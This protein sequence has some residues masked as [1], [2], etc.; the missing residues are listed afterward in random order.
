MISGVFPPMRLASLLAFTALTAAAPALAQTGPA[1]AAAPPQAAEDTAPGEIIVTATKRAENLQRVPIAVSVVSSADLAR[2]GGI[3]LENVQYLVPTLN[4]RKSGVPI[5]QSIF[6]RGVG[7]STF[8]IA[9][10]PSVS[11]VLDGVVLSRAGEAFTDLVDIERIEVLRGPQ[12]TLF[13]KNSSAGVVNIVSKKPTNKTQG[14][15]EGSYLTD[16]EFRARGSFNFALSPNL[17]TRLTGFYSDYDGNIRND[18]VRD[19]VNGYKHW[20]VRGTIVAD[21]SPDVHATLIGDYRKSRD[22]CCAEVIG[23]A[24]GGASAFLLGALPTPRGDRTRR[25]ANNT[26]NRNEEDS[27]GIS[28]QLDAEAHGITFTSITAY[29]DYSDREIRDGDFL[30]AAY[31]GNP[32]RAAVPATATSPALPAIPTVAPNQIADDGPQIGRTWSQELRLTSPNHGFLTYVAGFYF[33]HAYSQRTFTRSD[34]VCNFPAGTLVTTLIP[35]GS[36]SAP[37]STFPSGTADFGSVF[38][39]TALFGQTTLHFTDRLRGIV[40]LRY[41]LDQLDV[42]HRRVTTLAGP[43]IN[44][45]FDAG[46]YNNGLT[47]TSPAGVVSFVPGLSNGQYYR[48][49][50]N[51]ENLSGRAGLQYDL[52]RDVMAYGTYS[53]GYKGPAFNTFFNLTTTGAGPIAAE[54]AD[55]YEGGLK[56]AFLDRRLVLNL[57][58]YYAKYSNY[59]A[60]NPDVVAGVLTTRFT[61]AGDVSTRGGEADLIFRASR[62]INLSGG[63]AYTDAHVDRFRLPPGGNPTSVIAP[64]TPLGYAPRV[65]A[66]LGGEYRVRTT[67]LPVD[68]VLGAQ[69]S[70]QSSELSQFDASPAIRAATTIHSY[71]LLDLSLALLDHTDRYRLTLQVKN[72][73][74]QSFAA[75]ITSGGPGGAYRYII[76]READR[77]FGATLKVN[78]GA[79]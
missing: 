50:A 10:E 2:S 43:G 25:V 52:T 60:N 42:F 15:V 8:S 21:L 63:V 28:L 29:R 32:A 53:R 47:A 45:S 22:D 31:A 35:C 4:F 70:F 79:E 61:N 71:G 12:G 9:G 55:S 7:T 48:N 24:P 13:G 41:T 58:G 14:Y 3:N 77:F 39:N 30:P 17:R 57:A 1:D 26:V 36:A 38:I 23:T 73:L 75:S 65:K 62:D 69:G 19:R 34:I 20:G 74:D 78:Y 72:V 76:P 40:G 51:K 67:A 66:S 64:G 27:W 59:Q 18:S 16:D 11:T 56:M 54:T 33:S 6:L 44:P 68:F 5:N 49:R 37:P 46:V